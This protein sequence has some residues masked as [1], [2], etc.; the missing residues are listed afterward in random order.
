M[1]IVWTVVIL[2]TKMTV[3]SR[4][5]VVTSKSFSAPR[6]AHRG[7]RIIPCYVIFIPTAS[8]SV[9]AATFE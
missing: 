1:S 9:L 5:R 6:P 3:Y 4:R 2:T 8:L 7:S